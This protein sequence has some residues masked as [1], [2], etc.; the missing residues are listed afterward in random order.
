MAAGR[1][2]RREEALQKLRTIARI[3]LGINLQSPRHPVDEPFVS[4]NLVLQ[5]RGNVL[6]HGFAERQRGRHADN[7]GTSGA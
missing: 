4:I 6:L 3:F 5:R 1:R 2:K 7:R